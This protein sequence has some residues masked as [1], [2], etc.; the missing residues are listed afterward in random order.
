MTPAEI[1]RKAQREAMRD[2]WELLLLQQ[3]RAERLPEPSRQH[4]FA[5]P[6]K[7]AFDFAWPGHRIGPDLARSVPSP[8]AVEVEG[9]T[10]GVRCGKCR[11]FGYGFMVN[12]MVSCKACGGRRTVAGRHNSAEGYEGDLEKY[13]HA[14]ARG[15]QVYR[16]SSEMI[17]DGRAVKFLAEHVFTPNRR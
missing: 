10:K 2:Q 17:K 13:N 7:W 14:A 11:G 12:T 6:R 1:L 15:W 4:Q 5:L 9:G 16:F 8:I 3:M